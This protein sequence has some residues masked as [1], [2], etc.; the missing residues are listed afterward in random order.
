MEKVG[1]AMYNFI[2]NQNQSIFWPGLLMLSATI[3]FGCNW[4]IQYWWEDTGSIT[5]FFFK[6]KKEETKGIW[7]MPVPQWMFTPII[8][9][10]STVILD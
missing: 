5:T 6:G 3:K 7:P 1:N 4:A 2:L 9:E 8:S 10:E